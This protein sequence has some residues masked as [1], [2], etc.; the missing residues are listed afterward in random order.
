MAAEAGG[1][2][3]SGLGARLR[4]ARERKGL[5]VLQAAE[6]LHVDAKVV[7]SLE[8]EDFA[9]LGAPV[10]V[11]GHLR[12][13]AEIVGEPA[14]ELQELYSS[15]TKTVQPDLTRIPKAQ[16][17]PGDPGKLVIPALVVVIGFA[18]VG[19][20]S[21]VV[22][23]SGEKAPAMQ[24]RSQSSM[25]SAQSVSVE[26]A[27]PEVASAAPE[28]ARPD[29]APRTRATAGAAVKTA[30]A[31]KNGPTDKAKSPAGSAKSP[32][33]DAGTASSAVAS[34]SRAAQL[35]L[36]FSA[37]SWVEVYE[38]SGQRLYYDIG[39]ADSVHTMTG[40]PPL[41][42]VLGNASGV[43]VEINGRSA[44]IATMVHPDGSAQFL[45]SRSG[46]VVRPKPAADGG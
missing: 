4:S 17:A 15:T 46:R 31:G 2:V 33:K 39:T 40:S 1:N 8:A 10:Y 9:A 38:A 36:K 32:S 22:M 42:V 26:S 13:Y 27:A 35:T 16:D 20:I 25:S 30:A 12:H 11:R 45:V 37:D 14:A 6:K 24:I 7:E 43:A 44:A 34:T 41:R 23:L 5:T 19:S 21:W 29:S 28:A 18:V 3:R